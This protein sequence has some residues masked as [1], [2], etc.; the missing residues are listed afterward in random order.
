MQNWVALVRERVGALSSTPPDDVLV[1]E[2]ALHLAQT[3][4]EARADGAS[5]EGARQRA[6]RVLD[7][8]DL[9]RQTIAARRPA[10]PQRIHEWSRQ[11][12]PPACP[13]RSRRVKGTW[14]SPVTFLRDAH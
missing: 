5:E 14:M 2:L 4:E 11:E 1:E 10:L 9:L 3:Y 13:E 6:I 7:R 12:P 8:S